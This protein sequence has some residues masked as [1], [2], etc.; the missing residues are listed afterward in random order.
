MKGKVVLIKQDKSYWRKKIV[1][2]FKNPDVEKSIVNE[3]T[4]NTTT[5]RCWIWK[6]DNMAYSSEELQ[7][8]YDQFANVVAASVNNSIASK[9]AKENKGVELRIAK[10]GW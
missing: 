7:E 9:I 4:K 6:I 8:L 5:R 3:Y 2:L 10:R 1:E